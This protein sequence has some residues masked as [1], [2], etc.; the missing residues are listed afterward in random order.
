MAGRSSEFD[1]YIDLVKKANPTNPGLEG[2]EYE[3]AKNVYFDQ[4]YQKAII[5]LNSFLTSYPQTT[6]SQEAK[7]YIAE[8]HYRLREYDKALTLYRELS[9]DITFTNG[10]KV[11]A[12]IAEIEFKTGKYSDGLT[13]FHR[14]EKLATNKKEQYNAWSGLMESFYL[15]AQYDSA[16]VY[17]RESFWIVVTLTQELK[18]KP[19][20][21]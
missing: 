17:A 21:I 20:Y 10:S 12:R 8:S 5:S 11:V 16:D 19:P 18:T 1:K 13:S 15:L 7:Y 4:Q 2:L 9:N 3:T 6:K 14:L